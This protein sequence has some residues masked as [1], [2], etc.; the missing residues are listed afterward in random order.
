MG[1]YGK[2]G[3]EWNTEQNQ[4]F[5]TQIDNTEA[6][7][8]GFAGAGADAGSDGISS[9]GRYIETNQ[10]ECYL[11]YQF[12]E[13]GVQSGVVRFSAADYG[14]G[15][16]FNVRFFQGDSRNVQGQVC[17]GLAGV[18][19]E[20]YIDCVLEPAQVSE[21]I[22]IFRDSKNLDHMDNIPGMEVV[23][24]DQRA[25]FQKGSRMNKMS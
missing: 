4:A 22:E 13:S 8:Y 18:S 10:H 21:T 14:T 9:A 17:R 3:T 20:T 16:K 2:H 23:F 12:I 5:A 15:G 25:R 6:T 19:T 1:G 7:Q 11:A 24:N